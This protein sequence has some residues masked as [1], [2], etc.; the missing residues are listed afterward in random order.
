MSH[1]GGLP[2]HTRRASYGHHSAIK[3][4]DNFA[5]RDK[6]TQYWDER[7][8]HKRKQVGVLEAA[9]GATHLG[10]YKLHRCEPVTHMMKDYAL[11]E[12]TST[13]DHPNDLLGEAVTLSKEPLCPYADTAVKKV[14]R[15]TDTTSGLTTDYIWKGK[16]S[17]LSGDVECP[18]AVFEGRDNFV[19]GDSGSLL[20]AMEDN[21]IAR[22]IGMCF[23]T[24]DHESP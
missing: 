6:S 1:S 14:G 3:T 7:I 2:T 16:I 11:F 19:A 4:V 18:G 9:G 22:P 12:C 21:C 20:F 15:S 23:A 13:D 10:V 24:A 5:L 8:A 17:D